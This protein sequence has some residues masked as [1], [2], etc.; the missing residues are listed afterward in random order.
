[1]RE[2]TG[3]AE[4]IH[5]LRGE[6]SVRLRDA[7]L[8]RLPAIISLMNVIR[9]NRTS[10]DVFTSGDI[11]FTINGRYFNLNRFDLHGDSLSLKGEGWIAMDRQLNIVFHTILGGE[12]RWWPSLRQL[13]SRTSQQLLRIVVTGTIDDMRM[14]PEVLPGLN[15]LLPEQVKQPAQRLRR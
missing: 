9:I 4:G 6:G 3:S 5:T 1:M 11:D 13:A 15:D 12:K 10:P 14:T 2:L 8:A 7:N